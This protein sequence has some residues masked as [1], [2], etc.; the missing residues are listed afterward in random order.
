VASMEN[1]TVG[2]RELKQNPS[3]I[4][5]RAANGERFDVLSNGKPVG[6][7]IQRKGAI[8]RRWVS[9][10][11]LATVAGAQGDGALS[12]WADDIRAQRELDVDPIVDP[13][14]ASNL[15]ESGKP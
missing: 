2:I 4:I 10:E 5:A 13:W 9:A 3:D 12:A 7:V 11:V 14:G 15:P 1:Q 8:R 6:V